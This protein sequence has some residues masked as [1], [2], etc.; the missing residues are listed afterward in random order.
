MKRS[1][2]EEEIANA[3]R[4]HPIVALL[5]PHRGGK[6]TLAHLFQQHRK[7]KKRFHY[8]DLENPTDL[9]RLESPLLALQDLRGVIII[10]EIQRRPDLFP[11]LRVIVDQHK[12]RK[13]LILGSASGELLR[14]SSETLAGRIRY[15]ELTPFSFSEVGHLARLW[16]RGGFPR[17]YLARSN[18]ESSQWRKAYVTTFLERDIPTLGLN[19]A[20]AAL[21]RFWMM[22]AHLHGNVFNASELGRSLGVAHTTTRHYLD[23]LTAT[24]MIRELSPWFENISKRQ[25]KAPKV[26]FRDSGILHTLLGIEDRDGLLATPS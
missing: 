21:R 2:L 10:D 4:V 24:F 11:T 26:Y 25:L 22:L 14:Q 13:F 19:I 16:L 23:I 12:P 15:L 3:L 7:D 20:S 5:G 9:A 17:S 18:R 8:F 1:E 6:T